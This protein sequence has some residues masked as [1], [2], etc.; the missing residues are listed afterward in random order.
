MIGCSV[1]GHLAAGI[2]SIVRVGTDTSGRSLEWTIRNGVH[3]FM[4]LP[5]NDTFSG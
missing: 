4:R 5:M 2:H 3:S 1:V